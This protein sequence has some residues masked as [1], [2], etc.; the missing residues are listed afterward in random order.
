VASV[1]IAFAFVVAASIAGTAHFLRARANRLVAEDTIV[2]GDFANSTGDPI[3]DDTLKQALTISLRQSP[4]L[5]VLPES[6]VAKTL[7]LMTLDRS[8]ALT[9]GVA[10]EVCQR[11]GSKGYVAGAIGSLGSEY[12]VGLK[13]VNCH[14][15]DTIAQEQGT[16]ASKEQVLPVLGDIATKLRRELGESLVSVQKFD[17]PLTEATTSSLEALRAYSQGLKAWNTK[18]EGEAIPYLKQALELDPKFASAYVSLGTVYRNIATPGLA[19]ENYSKAYEL[20]DRASERERFYIMGHYYA[21]ITGELEK[22][23]P[24][25]EQWMKEYASDPTPR[26]N[27]A[28]IYLELGDF[29]K[30]LDRLRDAQRVEPN[31]VLI[32]ENIAL[33]QTY[34]NRLEDAKSTVAA[35]FAKNLDDMEL[36]ALLQQIAFFQKD[37]VGIDRQ[38]AWSAGKP[39][40][41]DTFLA[42][43]AEMQTF[44][45]HLAAA[46]MTNKKA[47]QSALRS[48]SRE[49]AAFYDV[50]GALR[51]VELGN[52][53]EA[54][55]QAET[56]MALAP[57]RDIQILAA[58]AFARAGKRRRAKSLLENLDRENP[59][60]TSLQIYWLPSIRAALRLER[61]D[62]AG[63]L[64]VLRS[65]APYELVAAR[66][67]VMIYPL[68]LRG[69]ALLKLR[70]P[71][72]AAAAFQKMQ[73]HRT[74]SAF[75][76][77]HLANLQLARCYAIASDLTAA[78]DAYKKFLESWKDADP[79]IPILKEARSEYA[80]LDR[81]P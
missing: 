80:K 75:V 21:D 41:E 4:F 53:Q 29:E 39:G 76:S 27:S 70:Q 67:Y 23:L 38:M 24:V 49:A 3:F 18:G 31:G 33:T 48:E 56:A 45:G 1:A 10:S 42:A 17:A 36:H 9:P 47:E 65:A 2:L 63:A 32:Y 8:A 43:Y 20:R 78:K 7:K 25:Y 68:Y 64:E 40:I 35:A 13:A 73:D 59:L 81:V 61:G 77:V 54:A 22:A 44:G 57:T 14:S 51:E 60:N 50:L 72:N 34:L 12:V 16:A 15:G 19:F 66:P 79:D 46:R 71:A 74:M 69:M 26:T 55:K 30:G 28:N 37:S 5:N 52:H 11:A 6:K 58:L 62:A